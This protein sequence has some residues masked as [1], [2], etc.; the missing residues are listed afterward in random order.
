MFSDRSQDRH[1][2]V[3]EEWGKA[4]QLRTHLRLSRPETWLVN[5]Q[6]G[7]KTQ[8]EAACHPRQQ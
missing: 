5:G 7:W 2:E 8:E 3:N 4:G 1:T 6:E